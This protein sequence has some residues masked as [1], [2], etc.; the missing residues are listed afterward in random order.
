[1]KLNINGNEVE[2]ANEELSKAI[3]AKQ[4]SIE[5]KSEL[6]IRTAA[7]DKTFSDNTRTEGISVGAEVGRKEVLKGFGLEGD[8]LHK[9]D[10]SSIAALKGFADT[11]VSEALAEAKIAPD[12]KVTELMGDITTLKGSIETLNT[13]NQTITNDFRSFKNNQLKVSALSG[14]IPENT[15]NSKKDTLTLMNASINTDVNEHG[16]VFGVGLDGQPMKDPTTLE[17]LPVKT[18]VANF[19][20]E[21]NDLLKPSAG[22]GGGGDSGGGSGKQSIE[23][24]IKEQKEAGN[25]ANSPEFNRIM[26]EKIKG[27]TLNV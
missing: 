26:E 20:N 19:F 8:G 13:T 25:D 21:R 10:A 18:I 23:D 17:L 12:K 2:I 15:I 27:G 22:G 1:M 9:S 4:E 24:F 7:D 6:V 16:V 14:E 3:E 5:I 11:K